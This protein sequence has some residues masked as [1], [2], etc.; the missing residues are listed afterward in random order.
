M[1]TKLLLIFFLLLL[2]IQ[3][4]AQIMLGIGGSSTMLPSND[5]PLSLIAPD[6]EKV[7]SPYFLISSAPV[8]GINI[9]FSAGG[10]SIEKW[11]TVS[12]ERLSMEWSVPHY[13]LYAAYRSI[14]GSDTTSPSHA[15]RAGATYSPIKLTGS[16]DSGSYDSFNDSNSENKIGP[17]IGADMVI[18]LST[19]NF[20]IFLVAE[21][22]FIT[23]ESDGEDV[24]LGELVLG[25][26]IAVTL[27]KK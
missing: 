15:I 13:N 22:S 19:S 11:V 17:Y 26:G 9:G 7:G 4:S 20:S 25:G 16:Y 2:P 6:G 10:Y 27:G 5:D 14:L 18:P 3:S 23:Y 12:S 1:Y 24:N 21:K 8:K